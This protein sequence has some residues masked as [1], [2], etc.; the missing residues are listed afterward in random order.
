MAKLTYED[1][2][3]EIKDNIKTY[4]SEEYQNYDMEFKQ[5]VNSRGEYE[6]LFVKDSDKKTSCTPALNIT[7]AYKD[8]Y[9]NNMELDDILRS[10]ADVRMNAIPKSGLVPTDLIHWNKCKNRLYP[11]LINTEK[12]AKYL[13]GKPTIAMANLS[14]IYYVLVGEDEDGIACCSVTN[15]LM[16]AWCKDQETIHEQAMANLESQPY[17]FF[18]LADAIN[19]RDLESSLDIDEIEPDEF[20]F[21][22]FMLSTRRKFKGAAMIMNHSV[23]EKIVAKLGKI[24]ILPSSTEEVLIVPK[25]KAGNLRELVRIVKSVNS[26]SVSP[27]EQLSDNVYEYDIKNKTLSIA[28]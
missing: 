24:V 8:Y 25:S 21:P 5:I 9:V 22:L 14:V 3:N 6:A 15:D 16:A 13:E 19:S 10:L 7:Q 23:M 18:N 2:K 27:E 17:L 12:N 20:E 26:N 4:L 11:R 1:F 28:I